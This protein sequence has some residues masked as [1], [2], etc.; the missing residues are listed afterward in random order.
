M[1]DSN[2]TINKFE[3][4]SIIGVGSCGCVYLVKDK[5]THNL[6]VMKILKKENK[7]NLTRALVE[8]QILMRINHPFISKL[9]YHIF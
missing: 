3:K 8:Q 6:Y 9:N 5:T 4:L 1:L 2:H 7:R